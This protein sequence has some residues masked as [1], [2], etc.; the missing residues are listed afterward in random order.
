[1]DHA[2]AP[3]SGE[4]RT[5]GSQTPGVPPPEPQRPDGRS[6]KRASQ[7][8]ITLLHTATVRTGETPQFFST[9]PL[10]SRR[11]AQ[12]LQLWEHCLLHDGT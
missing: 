8:A 9:T 10:E 1:M 4:G 3:Y 6:R 11:F 7:P 2:R 5:P 12:E